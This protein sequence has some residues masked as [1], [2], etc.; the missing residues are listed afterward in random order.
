MAQLKGP[1]GWG[2]FT[3]PDLHRCQLSARAVALIYHWRSLFVRLADPRARREAHTS[4]PWLMGSIGRKTD[5]AGQTTIS[6]TGL[7]A[8]FAKA[9]AALMRVSAMF[10]GWAKTTAEQWEPNVVWQRVCNYLKWVLA[11]FRATALPPR[12]PSMLS[13]SGNCGFF[14]VIGPARE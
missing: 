11:R 14:G 12:P 13:E 8:D 5:H 4:R 10:Q 7:H 3:T 2:G 9:K 6:L 1:W